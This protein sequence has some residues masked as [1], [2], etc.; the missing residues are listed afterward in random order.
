MKV[1]HVIICALFLALAGLTASAQQ[2]SSTPDAVK[3]PKYEEL[4]AKLKGGDTKIDY[5]AL[6][7][8]YAQT[9]DA[10]PYG[11]GGDVRVAMNKALTAKNYK[12]AIKSADAILKDDYVNP[13]AHLAEAIAYS[14]LKDN[15]KYEFHKAVYLGLI[16]SIL[17]GADGKT[18]ETAYTVIATE[19]EYAV[20]QALKFQVGGQSLN[21]KNGH[22]F[23]VL[24]GTDSNGAKVDVWFNIDIVW[25]METKMFG[26]KN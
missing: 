22:T 1:I 23:D 5:K 12:D 10:S 14:E 16:N 24:H 18:P 6:R 19:E 9:K 4:L 15:E 2:P 11:S 8:A 17:Q 21:N 7:L 13:Y 20:M 25:A 3:G 26:P